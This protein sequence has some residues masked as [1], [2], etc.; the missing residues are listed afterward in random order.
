MTRAQ[1]DAAQMLITILTD[2]ATAAEM[3]RELVVGFD[4]RELR[5]VGFDDVSLL[6]CIDRIIEATVWLREQPADRARQAQ[7]GDAGILF[8]SARQEAIVRRRAGA[9]SCIAR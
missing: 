4:E 6:E 7:L 5:R 2:C 9:A 3:R 8:F 1:A